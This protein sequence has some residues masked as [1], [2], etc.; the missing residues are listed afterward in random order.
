M[1]RKLKEP[2]R[3][4][5]GQALLLVVILLLVGTLIVVS[6]LGFMG[7]GLIAGQVFEKRM[8]ELYA[9]DAGIEDAIWQIIT[10]ATGLPAE[11]DDPMEYSIADVNGKVVDP[12]IITYIN[13]TTYKINS[14]ATTDAGSKTTIESYINILSLADFMNNSIT[15]KGPVTLR[16][17]SQVVG[18]P[19]PGVGDVVYGAG[20]D[21]PPDD[22]VIDGDVRPV[23]EDE[24]SSW[25]TWD[26][27]VLYYLQALADEGDPSPVLGDYEIDIKD[28]DV[29]GPLYVEGDLT[30]DNTETADPLPR[31]TLNGTVYVTGDLTFQQSG[32]K[33]YEVDLNGYTIFVEGAI[34]F[35]PDSCHLFGPG[36][37]IAKGDID[38]QPKMESW[39]ANTTEDFIFVMSVEGHVNFQPKGDFYGSLAGNVEVKLQPGSTLTWNGPP[40]TLKYPGSDPSEGNVIQEILTWESSIQ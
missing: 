39:G 19:E 29:I 36:C 1:K 23:T 2:G 30:I 33:H 24:L 22:Q 4:E 40:P 18:D 25:P 8:A 20:T 38:F 12:V 17:G 13:E 6:L 26:D 16:S 14:T 31:L 32:S 10:K 34:T 7:T 21:P 37:I 28:T 15:S 27:L 11:G 5:S 35:P 9:A 3:G